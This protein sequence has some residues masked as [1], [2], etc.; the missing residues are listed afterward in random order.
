MSITSRVDNKTLHIKVN[1]ALT[2]DIFNQFEEAYA[3]KEVGQIII[4]LSQCQHIDSGGLGMLLQM[5]E[6]L[7]QDAN[8]ITLKNMSDDIQKIFEVVKFKQLFKMA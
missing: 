4:D 7:G 8:K 6:R 3:Q 5:R 2:V 1:G